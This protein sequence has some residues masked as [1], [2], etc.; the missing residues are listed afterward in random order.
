[1][2]PLL[3]KNPLWDYFAIPIGCLPTTHKSEKYYMYLK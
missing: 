3:D 2:C 1:M